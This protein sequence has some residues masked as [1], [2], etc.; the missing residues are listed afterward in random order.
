MES[1]LLEKLHLGYET[2]LASEFDLDKVATKDEV[3]HLMYTLTQ[4]A[5]NR[6]SDLLLL[7]KDEDDRQ[8]LIKS[9]VY[10]FEEGLRRIFKE[11]D[12]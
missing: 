8:L 2:V 5:S 1:K 3:L 4:F 7:F 6:V 9:Q 11:K 10:C 12:L